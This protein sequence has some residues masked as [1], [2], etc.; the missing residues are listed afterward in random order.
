MSNALISVALS[1]LIQ[2]FSLIGAQQG[3][4]G[5]VNSLLAIGA[6]LSVFMLQ[7][8]TGKFSM[9]IVAMSILS[10]T[11][12]AA[13]VANSFGVMLL[14]YAINGVGIGYLETYSSAVMLDLHPQDSHLYMGVLHGCF[15]VGGLI[16]PLL[17]KLILDR[18]SWRSMYV[19]FGILLFFI[20]LQA[21]VLSRMLR[22]TGQKIQA[23]PERKL[24][25]ADWKQYLKDPA[26]PLLWAAMFLAMGGQN[27][28]VYYVVT[29]LSDTLGRAD[30]APVALSLFWISCTACRFIYPRLKIG[31]M[32]LLQISSLLCAACIAI[33]VLSGSGM[34]MFT[35]CGF[36]GFC[37]APGIPLI[38]GEGGKRFAHMSA[39]PIAAISVMCYFSRAVV[40]PVM[41]AVSR[42]FSMTV[43]LLVPVLIFCCLA[44]VGWA[45]EK[46]LARGCEQ[47]EK[48][49]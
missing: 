45:L 27:G 46:A 42:T 26:T 30:I 18:F 22:R 1:D 10:I 47:G 32:R 20:A 39:L 17:A 29:F 28:F 23:Q 37:T 21:V 40:P 41:G 4:F 13:G 11:L 2:E 33:G 6:I 14:A 25:R 31:P 3:Y 48:E 12:L 43:A 49:V 8:R 7:G 15:G 36:I 35:A 34:V 16:A 24:T 19:S 9:L 38:Y 5:M 44:V